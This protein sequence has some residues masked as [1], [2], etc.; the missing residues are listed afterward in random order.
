[1]GQ[2]WAL[3]NE[4]DPYA[5]DWLENLIAAGHIAPGIVD[6]RSI[7]DVEAD[8]LH[9]FTQI[10]WFAGIAGWSCA[11]R[12]AGYPDDRRIWTASLPCQPFSAAGQQK[13]MN[14]DRHLWPVFYDLVRKCRPETIVGEQVASSLIVGP[15]GGADVRLQEM[16]RRE[17]SRAFRLQYEGAS[18]DALSRMH[19]PLHARKE[20]RSQTEEFGRI[21]Q[22]E[23]KQS[24]QG[25]MRFGEIPRIDERLA[26][27]TERG[28]NPISNRSGGMRSD[29][30]TVRSGPGADLE[31][32][33][34]RPH[35]FD[36][37]VYDRQ[38]ASSPMGDECDGEHLGGGHYPECCGRHSAE[39]EDFGREQF[40]I[41]TLG[42][43]DAGD[44]ARPW[45]DVVQTDLERAGY[46]FGSNSANVSSFGGPHIRQRLYWMAH[47]DEPRPQGWIA[48]P[49]CADQRA[50][51]S[52]GVAERLDD[53]QS[54]GR[55]G[56]EPLGD[57]RLA[58]S[59]GSVPSATWPN[60]LHGPWRDADWL[61]C[62]DARWRPVEPGA[63]ALVSSLPR[64]MGT[65]SAGLGELAV[66]AGADSRSLRDAQRYRVGSLR[67]YGNAICV[68][69]A[70]GWM[71]AVMACVL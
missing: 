26:V 12:R 48:L 38:C 53:A 43:E 65:L 55:C 18:S 45:L 57:G 50:A 56:R 10:N 63:T 34:A 14:D 42:G 44:D 2:P 21:S 46:A 15:S 40:I 30:N 32:P 49:E 61:F 8:G 24:G 66:L 36:Q 68:E 39:A 54:E 35:R 29:G 7:V 71:R 37:G 41:A 1:M 52:D 4:I 31:Q 51:G 22:M 5:A 69:Q 28:G 16:W 58:Q 6:R 67:G 47:A 25:L 11:L 13:A 60:P 9:E 17:I 20:T 23:A 70:E 64:G 19:E 27:R 59:G 62:S 3:Y 33:L